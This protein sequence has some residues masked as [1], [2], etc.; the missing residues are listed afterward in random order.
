MRR[1]YKRGAILALAALLL[2]PVPASAGW[3][4]FGSA[5]VN[6]GR[7][8]NPAFEGGCNPNYNPGSSLC[9]L[10][11][12]DPRYDPVV[13]EST[14]SG[15][16][17][18]GNF[19]GTVLLTGG[20]LG[21]WGGTTFDLVYTPGFYLYETGDLNKLSHALLSKWTHKTG[22]RGTFMLSEDFSYTPEQEV[23]P[24][25]LSEGR[26]LL[27]R[28]TRTTNDFRTG[29]ETET[30]ARTSLAGLYRWSVREFGSERFTDAVNHDVGL[31][32]TGRFNS[33]TALSVG[34]GF[35]TYAFDDG[36]NPSAVFQAGTTSGAFIDTHRSGHDPDD[37]PFPDPGPLPLPDPDP[38]PDDPSPDP[39]PDPSDDFSSF[40][41]LATPLDTVLHQAWIGY[42]Y[43][44]TEAQALTRPR[45][46]RPARERRRG[47]TLGL[48]AGYHRLMAP[49]SD[50]GTRSSPYLDGAFSWHTPPV[51]STFGYMR[52]L[53]DGGGA[54]S[55]A[56]TQNIYADFRLHV[57]SNWGAI[58]SGSYL[59]NER[60]EFGP[61]GSLG[62]DRVRTIS[63][64]AGM[65]YD[66]SE[67][68]ILNGAVS[69][70]HQEICGDPCSVLGRTGIPELSAYRI[71]TGITWITD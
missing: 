45:A 19:T 64:R 22:P 23:D 68:W 4:R 25:A 69:W 63:T 28:T 38:D 5:G 56:E 48:S 39:S 60:V 36:I 18:Q 58:L 21:T 16:A 32:F 41:G 15:D 46:G 43:D 1:P 57:A 42:T 26:V 62:D 51:S 40:E 30:T 61:A 13:C 33:R 20:L 27:Q 14:L 49:D 52:G 17:I 9:S 3:E 44:T 24:N 35:G 70:F 11:R 29:Y 54:F 47:I 71:S 34:Y 8:D 59:V 31:K 67:R 55:N 12:D 65:E 10:P 50:E 6:F 66:L 7:T 53:T 37:D 2:L